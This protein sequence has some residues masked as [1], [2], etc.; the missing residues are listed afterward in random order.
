MASPLHQ[1]A[2]AWGC[3]YIPAE[4]Q[5]GQAYWKLLSVDGPSEWGGRHSVFVDVLGEA[6][7]RLL[8]LPVFFWWADGKETKYTEAKP[9]DPFAVDLP[10]YASGNSYG[11]TMVGP[12]KSD[13]VWGFGLPHLQPH[14]VFHVKFQR[15]L[16]EGT[17]TQPD[18]PGKTVRE[19]LLEAQGHINYALGLLDK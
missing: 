1:N 16:A 3:T 19:A 2:I 12:L 11:V 8:G 14:H 15:T 9:G 17:P 13:T 7:Q 5:P 10:M 6:G 18:P 4:V